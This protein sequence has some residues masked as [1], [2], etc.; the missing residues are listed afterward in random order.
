[1]FIYQLVADRFPG[2]KEQVIADEVANL[3]SR[4]GENRVI[5]DNVH[6]TVDSVGNSF[7]INV[8]T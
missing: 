4:E 8:S 7:I 2:L 5:H 6:A 1:M 3:Y